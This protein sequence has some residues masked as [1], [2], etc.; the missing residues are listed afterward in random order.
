MLN[1]KNTQKIIRKIDYKLI[2]T[3]NKRTVEATCA[4]VLGKNLTR[5]ERASNGRVKVLDTRETIRSV[6]A[7]G[8]SQCH[9]NRLLSHGR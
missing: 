8:T 7:P 4:G 1:E 5:K 2:K 3:K 9:D 6:P